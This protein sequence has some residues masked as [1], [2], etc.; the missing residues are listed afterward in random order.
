MTAW[1]TP[2]VRQ[3]E[4]TDTADK[5]RGPLAN[6]PD[7]SRPRSLAGSIKQLFREAIKLL[8]EKASA[9]E[10]KP[11]RKRT[12]EVTGRAFR[13]TANKVMHRAARLPAEAYA[14]ATAYL[15]DTL[16]WINPWHQHGHDHDDLRPA[17]DDHLYPHL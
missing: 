9:P 11:R 17:P 1:R 3:A 4:I 12:G 7:S 13:M 10:P 16:D 5:N 8:A 14:T 6:Q 15:T 2:I